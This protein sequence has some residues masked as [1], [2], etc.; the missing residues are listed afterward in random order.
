MGR[1]K[2]TDDEKRAK[3]TF[4]PCRAETEPKVL[5]L[6]RMPIIPAWICEEG[7][8]IWREQGPGLLQRGLLTPGDI[9][10]FSRY[11]QFSGLF[12]KLMAELANEQL[13]VT[14]PNGVEGPNQKFKLA[15][16]CQNQ[17]DKIGRQFGFTPSTRK[18]VPTVEQK[19]EESPFE[20]LLKQG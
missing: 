17:A 20:K 10:A 13:V 5:P 6:S 19:R 12:E 15:L 1:D 2:T 7:A 16:D 18:N 8:R 9:G 3:G 14:M 11:C 4:Q